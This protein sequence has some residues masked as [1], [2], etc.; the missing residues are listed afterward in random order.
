MQSCIHNLAV[1]KVKHI[2]EDLQASQIGAH[3]LGVRSL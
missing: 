2:T 3:V 1:Q